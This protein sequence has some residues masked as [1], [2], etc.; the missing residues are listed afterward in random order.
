MKLADIVDVGAPLQFSSKYMTA[1]FDGRFIFWCRW[2][3]GSLLDVSGT[4]CALSGVLGL[5]FWLG[6]LWA[7]WVEVVGA[8]C[9]GVS[10][11]SVVLS[12][13]WCLAAESF[14]L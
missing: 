1:M 7:L 11:I 14:S 4:F 5:P 10:V 13:C 3:F 2:G 6:S 9:V 12:W 8:S